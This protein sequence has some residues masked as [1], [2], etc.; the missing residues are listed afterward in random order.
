[1]SA[2]G[3]EFG[4]LTK[5]ERD[6]VARIEALGFDSVWCGGHI[7][8]RNPT[9]ET[10]VQ[11]ARLSAFAERMTVG[12]AVL[13]LPLYPPAVV[14]KQALDLDIA[15]S[16]RFVLGIGVAGEYAQEF[17]ACGVPVEQRGAR[18][19][20]SIALIRRFWS[21][22]PVSF[23]GRHYTVDDVVL[24]PAPYSPAGP[25]IVVAGRQVEAMRRAAALGDG[26]LPYLYSPRRY[27]ASARTI[28]ELAAAARRDMTSFRWCA[29][30]FTNVHD[31]GDKARSE[32][33]GYLS[34]NYRRD[35][36]PL[37]EAVAAA[38]TAAEV[39]ARIQS[40]I[41]AGARHLVIAPASRSRAV[42]I[43]ERVAAEVIPGLALRPG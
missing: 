10:M 41:G 9:P 36:G 21:G 19:D 5:A 43:V 34:G 40:F 12:T 39:R 37:V 42:D 11:A 28:G 33:A 8:S 2:N 30:L 6:I 29:F 1:M 22:N 14:A 13:P 25:P 23:Y 24:R 3:L 27:A 31:D 7:A 18:T 20:E 16:G 38:G 35:F 17:R 4:V 32:A 26:W 15:T